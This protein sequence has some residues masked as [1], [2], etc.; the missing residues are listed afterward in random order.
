AV[1]PNPLRSAS[2]GVSSFLPFG[3]MWFVAKGD[4]SPLY[5]VMLGVVWSIVLY[6]VCT[7]ILERTDMK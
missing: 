2:S 4:M 1:V 3:A 6:A 7:A 5:G